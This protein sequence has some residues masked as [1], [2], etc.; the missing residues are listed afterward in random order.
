M[1]TILRR[2]FLFICTIL[3]LICYSCDTDKNLD[4]GILWTSAWSPDGNYIAV[5]G[6]QGNLKLFD[7][8]SYDLI[9]TYPVDS[10]ILSRLKWHPES[11]LL[12][13]VTQHDEV[14]ARILNI[15]T[16]TWIPLEGL[17]QSSRGVDWN[18]S[19]TLLAV[20]EFEG[21]VSVFTPEGKRV[22]RFMA[23][24]MSVTDLDWHPTEDIMV[25]VGSRAGLYNVQGDS[26]AT[27][28]V[29]DKKVLLLCTKWHPSGA[30]FAIGD[31]GETDAIGVEN[32]KLQFWNPNGE[33]L[34][35]ITDGEK[36]YRNIRWSPDGTL[37]ASASEALRIWN[38]D[39]KMLFESASSEDL[40]WGVDWSPDGKFIVTSSTK[41]NIV[42]WDHEANKIREL[43]Y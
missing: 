42:L 38:Q 33:K 16:D 21:E 19:G 23:D 20:S 35:E 30:F 37:L 29:R 7:G 39:G 5:G 13:V 28:D 9:K 6:R 24:P 18:R 4:R 22:S 11:K 1:K 3:S 17:E 31:Y 26:I 8:K 2:S 14:V 10:V 43:D 15:I 40:L 12:A 27:F 34:H 25:T 32:V 36:E 41:G